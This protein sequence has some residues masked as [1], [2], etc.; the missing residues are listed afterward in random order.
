MQLRLDSGQGIFFTGILCI[1]ICTDRERDENIKPLNLAIGKN[2]TNKLMISQ[3]TQ[4][5]PKP[6]HK[7]IVRFRPCFKITGNNGRLSNCV[8][9]SL[10]QLL[11]FP[12]RYKTI[13]VSQKIA[14][15]SMKRL[16]YL[17]RIT[18]EICCGKWNKQAWFFRFIPCVKHWALLPLI[19][20]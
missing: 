15:W 18:G 7:V 9:R 1:S 11:G 10:D 6:L 8:H 17:C 5:K 3:V 4:K 2:R 20:C 13:P 14:N 16:N 12:H 19:A